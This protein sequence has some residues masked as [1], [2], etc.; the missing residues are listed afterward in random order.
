M[1][2]EKNPFSKLDP[3][4]ES[5]GYTVSSKEPIVNNF[6]EVLGPPAASG[7]EFESNR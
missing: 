4:I 3:I 5:V 2:A 6:I 7:S 1:V